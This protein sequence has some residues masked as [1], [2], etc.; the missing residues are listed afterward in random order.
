M[1]K[2]VQ[3]NSRTVPATTDPAPSRPPRG[4]GDWIWMH[5]Y[6]EWRD[7][8][9]KPEERVRQD[10]ILHLHNNVSGQTKPF[11]TFGAYWSGGFRA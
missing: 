5:L 7:S 1:A 4:P 8:T 10:F 11:W 2:K 3:R 9:G 6:R